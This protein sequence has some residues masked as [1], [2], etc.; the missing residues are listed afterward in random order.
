[1]ELFAHQDE[2]VGWL[3]QQIRYHISRSEWLTRQTRVLLDTEALLSNSDPLFIDR[4][5]EHS[6]IDEAGGSSGDANQRIA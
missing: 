5:S 2:Y 3:R 4:F 1:M 6:G